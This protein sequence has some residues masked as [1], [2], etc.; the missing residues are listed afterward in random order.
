M[1]MEH[2][3]VFNRMYPGPWIGKS[4]QVQ[5]VDNMLTFLRGMLG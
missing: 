4:L 5:N 2:G 3:K 1:T